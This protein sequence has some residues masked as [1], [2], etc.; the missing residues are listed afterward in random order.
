[1]PFEK[2]STNFGKPGD[3]TPE[4]VEQF[5]QFKILL[6]TAKNR[7][8]IVALCKDAWIEVEPDED[9]QNTATFRKKTLEHYLASHFSLSLSEKEQEEKIK[10]HVER[11]TSYLCQ[12]GARSALWVGGSYGTGKIRSPQSDIDLFFGLPKLPN[13]D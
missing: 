1:M 8:D 10:C 7:T 12:E 3:A 4:A 2:H 5:Y 13:A 9:I 11:L 6:R